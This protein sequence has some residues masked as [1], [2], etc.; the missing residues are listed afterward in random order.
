[1]GHH[2]EQYSAR[3]HPEFVVLEIGEDVGALIIH[4]D[5]E[6]HGTEIEIS[7][8]HDDRRRSHKEVLERLTFDIDRVMAGEV[9]RVVSW[10]AIPPSLSPPPETP[11][12]FV[13]LP[14][15]F[16][17][18]VTVTGTVC[19]PARPQPAYR[20]ARVGEPPGSTHRAAVG[21]GTVTPPTA[22]G[23]P[24]RGA[25]AVEADNG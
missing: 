24:L 6:L 18:T 13:T 21:W 22:P 17:A 7:P 19:R 12:T 3:K 1:M 15:A 4:A 16:W 11:A 14:G 25:G 5:P 2:H 20:A 9:W 10:L 23:T 8:A